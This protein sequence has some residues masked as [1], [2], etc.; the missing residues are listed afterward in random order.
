MSNF[1]PRI[2]G[3]REVKDP[4]P[5]CSCNQYYLN[6]DCVSCAKRQ[7]CLDNITPKDIRKVEARRQIEDLKIEQELNKQYGGL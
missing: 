7:D 6:G 3:N 1:H 4:C 5:E 2:S